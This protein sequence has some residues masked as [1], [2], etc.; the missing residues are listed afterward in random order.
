[1]CIRD[2][3]WDCLDKFTEGR[4]MRRYWP[5]QHCDWGSAESDHLRSVEVYFTAVTD[6]E[7]RAVRAWTCKFSVT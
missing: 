6:K 7:K 5:K 3:F 2:S 4:R 1:M